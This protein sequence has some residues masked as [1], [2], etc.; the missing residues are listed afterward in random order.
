MKP[1]FT[2]TH[3]CLSIPR[4]FFLTTRL[5]TASRSR[6]W[7]SLLVSSPVKG[8][9]VFIMA[10]TRYAVWKIMFPDSG[11][12]GSDSR[13]CNTSLTQPVLTAL[14]FFLLWSLW[15]FQ[16]W[17]AQCTE[18]ILLV[19]RPVFISNLE[20]SNIYYNFHLKMVWFFLL[21]GTNKANAEKTLKYMQRFTRALGS[22]LSVT[23]NVM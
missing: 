8:P 14:W 17:H 22:Q 3:I 1:D 16:G 7:H 15:T 11:W 9:V 10:W 23:I 20:G 12:C 2:Q 18:F 21:L 4:C 19:L 13:N 6:G 5:R